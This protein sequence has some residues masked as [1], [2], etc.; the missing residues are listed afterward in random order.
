MGVTTRFGIT[1]RPD[2]IFEKEINI[3]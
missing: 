1:I 2:R 3:D